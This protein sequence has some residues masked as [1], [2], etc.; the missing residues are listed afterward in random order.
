MNWFRFPIPSMPDGAVVTYPP[1]W[2]GEMTYPPKPS[3]VTVLLYD[4]V[5]RFGIARTDSELIMSCAKRG[6]CQIITE[7][8]ALRA[9]DG[10]EGSGVF[11]GQ[12]I[13]DRYLP[14]VELTDSLIDNVIQAV[15][16]GF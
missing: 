14:K 2:F 12:A 8:E 10:A 7:A 9:V 1:G 6:Q 13:A 16:R 4:E 11:K 5:K 3:E 15:E